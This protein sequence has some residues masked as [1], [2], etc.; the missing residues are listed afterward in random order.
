M[1]ETGDAFD[2]TMKLVWHAREMDEAMDDVVVAIARSVQVK[3]GRA[4]IADA[5]LSAHADAVI[6][7]ASRDAERGERIAEELLALAMRAANEDGDGFDD[8][9]LQLTVLAA[10]AV[11]DVK[12]AQAMLDE[13]ARAVVGSTATNTPVGA[14]GRV[15]GASSP[16]AAVLANR[17]SAMDAKKPRGGA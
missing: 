8:V 10:I 5:E 14:G 13:K 3:D 4:V 1:P 7:A 11:G 9:I 2:H 15:A 6:A 17:T 16:I 12:H